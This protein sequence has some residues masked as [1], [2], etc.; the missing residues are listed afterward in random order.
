[1]ADKIDPFDVEAL[2]EAVND[3]ASR[4]STIWISFLIFSLYMLV[5]A[6]TVT[7]RQLFLD[8]PTKLPVLNIDLPLWWF[9]LLAPILFVIFH[10][11]VLL[12]VLLLGRTAAAY[13]AAVTSLGLSPD[14]NIS[15]RQRLANTIFAQIFA[16]SPRERDGFIGSLLRGVVWITLAIA[17]ILILLAFQFRFLPYHSETV[18]LTHRF[19]IL[20]E[21]MAFFLIWPLALDARRD[22]Q[23]PNVRESLKHLPASL[24]RPDGS[25]TKRG[26]SRL[27]FWRHAASLTACFLYIIICFLIASFPGEPH[28]NLLTGHAWS[29]VQ[30]DRWLQKKFRYVDL[31]FDRLDPPHVDVIDFEKFE[32]IEEATKK[33]GEPPYQGERTRV[34]RDRDLNCGDF[35][36]YSDLRRIDLTVAHLRQA[37]FIFAKL[38]GA[39]LSADLQGAN[40]YGAN[41]QGAN[42][43]DARLQDANLRRANFQGAFLERAQ[44]WRASL[45]EAKLQGADLAHADIED[46]DLQGADLNGADLHGAYLQSANLQDANLE[47]DDLHGANLRGANL[48]GADLH[49][50]DLHRADLR[51]ANLQGANLQ[52]ANLQ[53]SFGPD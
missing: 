7:H 12:Q 35:S 18:T 30:C 40:L 10:V 39:S 17:P 53:F 24:E 36:N 28:V 2:G 19:L 9:F 32:K 26:N 3:S 50:A 49:G 15:L 25:S 37:D 27:W 22:F 16:G 20:I 6:G 21:L 4:V 14:G 46:A 45:I 29:S 5:A 47:G 42:V 41:L 13:D 33:A 34:L 1:M 31:Q 11:Y 23:W 8:E 44:I 48:Q 52:G 51:G 43:S 38:Q